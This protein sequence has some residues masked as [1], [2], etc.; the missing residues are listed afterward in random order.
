MPAT[1]HD[2]LACRLLRILG[3]LIGVYALLSL[4]L[5]P[6]HLILLL[7]GLALSVSAGVAV[8][9]LPVAATA[10][11]QQTPSRGD[12]L[13]VGI[14]FAGLSGVALRIESILARD[15]AQPRILNTDLAAVSIFSGLL[16]LVCF[17]WAPYASEGRVP[18]ER[19]GYAGL[20]VAAG[21]GLAFTVSAAHHFVTPSP[22][23][24]FE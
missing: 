23:F 24:R 1:I 20:M 14:F 19:W 9:Y 8:A 10:L 21:V 7:N 6:M 5:R 18:R 12:V 17:L 4:C 22:A 13:G 2:C 16:G 11:R 3:G 15:L